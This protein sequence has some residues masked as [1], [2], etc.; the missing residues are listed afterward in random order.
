[1]IKNYLKAALRNLWRSKSFS[2]LNIAGLAAG[3]AAAILILVWIYNEVSYDRFHKN[4]DRLYWAWNRG[5][6]DGRIECWNSTPKILGQAMKLEYP[7]VEKFTRMNHRWFVTHYK[8]LNL[9]T[10]AR[11]VDP[12]FLTMFSFPLKQGDPLT[13]LN[14]VYSIVI[15]ESMATKMFGKEDAMNKVIRIDSNNFTVTG[16]MENLPTN[17]MFSFEMI[18]PWAYMKA[19]NHDDD[20]WGNNSASNFVMLKPGVNLA[21]FAEKIKNI[22]KNH[23]N[24]KEQQE[25]FLHPINKWHLYSRFENGKIVGGKIEMVRLFIII[26]VFILLIAC[27]NFMNLSTAR[28]EK[29]AREVGIRKVSG[30]NKGLLIGQFLGESTLLALISG[31][32]AIIIVQISLPS[33]NLLIGKQLSIPFRSA[34]FWMISIMFVFVTGVIAGS[35]PAFFLSSFSPVK[36][37]K[38]TFKQANAAVNPRKI[39]VVTQFTFAIVLI[40]CT[41]IIVQ[42]MR[43]AMER[44]TGYE[45]SQLAYVWLVGDLYNKYPLFKEEVIRSGAV[46]SATRSNGPMT[47]SYSTTWSFGWQGKD[48]NDKTIFIRAVQDEGLAE[49]VGLKMIAGRDLNLKE[50]PTDSN[51]IILNES[52][53]NAMSFK[54]PMGQIVRDGDDEYHVVGFFKDVVIT[55]PYD[56]ILPMVI[57]GSRSNWF[58]VIHMRLNPARSTQANVDQ[59]G[60]VFA[61]FT[62]GYPYNIHFTDDDYNYKFTDERRTATLTGLF[63]GLTII[64]SCLGLFGLAAY[65]A[66]NRIKEIG[67]RKVLGASVYK[68]T[69]LL[70]RDFLMLVVIS[71]VIACPIAWFVMHTWLQGYDYRVGIE[72]WVFL[73]AG[74]LSVLISL[75]TVSF[76]S[77]R[78]ALANPVKSL[79]NE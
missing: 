37:L 47:E 18:L 21:T 50:F 46:T 15:T 16:V 34:N 71:L 73:M 54:E 30:A 39:L 28:S 49:T 8:D 4:G 2:F 53:A 24:G 32:L 65:M 11:I 7:E 75:I 38:G 52:A 23:T 61:K 74:L 6:F 63:A 79:R 60:K 3:M 55:S 57:E 69:T 10:E 67:I 62:P 27:I 59:I 43:H 56:K 45:R 31:I 51:A 70:S 78:A 9:V 58:N 42:Q 44:E 77:I 17:T 19:I 68:I 1:M 14:S 25:V 5:V 29:R 41:V 22:T 64:I 40:I 36:V 26:A 48:P 33:F 35:Y 66:E 12:D 76:Q 72:W 20:D 13:A